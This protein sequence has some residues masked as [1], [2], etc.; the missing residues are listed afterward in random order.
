M[1]YQKVSFIRVDI[2]TLI[3]HEII[4]VKNK[5]RVTNGFGNIE[6]FCDFSK[7]SLNRGVRTEAWLKGINLEAVN[8]DNKRELE[9]APK[10]ENLLARHIKTHK[11][12]WKTTS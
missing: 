3:Y 12:K 4:S 7:S 5:F 9:K 6:A 10:R 2:L 8:H 11:T 1:D